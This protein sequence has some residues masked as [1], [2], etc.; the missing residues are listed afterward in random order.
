MK[1][2]LSNR[3]Q[4][5]V[6]NGK[7]SNWTNVTSGVPQGSVLG[8]VL[9]LVYINDIDEGVTGI[10][11]KFADD[12]KIANTVVSSEQKKE[13]QNNLDKL[14]EWGQR[15]QMSFNEN[16]CKV[17]HIGYRNDKTIYFLNGTQLK[18][19]DSEVDLGV[20]ISN[21]LKPS[22]QCSEV[23]KKANKIIGLIGR[24]FEYKSKNTILTLYTSLV[25]PLLEYCVQAWCPY[26]QKD[27]DKLERVQRRVTKIIPSLRNKSYEERLEELNLF[28][29]SQRR[30]RGDLIQTFK[31]IK[32]IDNMDCNKYFTIDHSNYT[33]GNGCKIVGKAF[34]SHESK[35][36]LFHRVVNPWNRLPRDVIDCNT[37]DSFKCHLDKYFA[38]NPQ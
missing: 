30:L 19:V 27:I 33:R 11:S 10:I 12:T 35:N 23:I 37:V 3:K 13:M 2:W 22:Q 25:R 4:R 31:I 20:T 15:W 24:S 1:N 34:G 17:M 21:N 28:P 29:L 32:G 26:Y 38:S 36:H 18:S 14:S 9:F 7:A 8:P 5:V 6:I 16:K